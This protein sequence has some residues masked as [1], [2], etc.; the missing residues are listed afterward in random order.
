MLKDKPISYKPI[1]TKDASFYH[2]LYE[3][4][5]TEIEKDKPSIDLSVI[6]KFVVNDN[7]SIFLMK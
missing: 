7:L 5:K 3:K 4:H 6:L 1:F 2:F